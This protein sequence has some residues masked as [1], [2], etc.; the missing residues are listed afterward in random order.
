[1]AAAAA[2]TAGPGFAA[3]S[4]ISHAASARKRAASARQAAIV[5]VRTGSCAGAGHSTRMATS[6]ATAA[7]PQPASR[8][9]IDAASPGSETG[10]MNASSS[11][12]VAPASTE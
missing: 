9:G 10:R 1:M 5:A 4:P 2:P 7:S 8:A 6:A 11:A 12:V 3:G